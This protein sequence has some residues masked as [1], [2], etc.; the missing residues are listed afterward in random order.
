MI[1]KLEGARQSHWTASARLW[2]PTT[3]SE[4]PNALEIDHGLP[5]VV[6]TLA[7]SSCSSVVARALHD[8][9]PHALTSLSL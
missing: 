2:A 8:Q 7:V 5:G 1:A 4:H 9:R 3:E 6:L